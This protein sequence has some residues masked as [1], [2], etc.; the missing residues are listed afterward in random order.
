MWIVGEEVR[1]NQSGMAWGVLFGVVFVKVFY[2]IGPMNIELALSG[3]ISDPVKAHV[4]YFQLFLLDGVV[5]KTLSCGVI[6]TD[7]GD[8][9]RIDKLCESGADGYRFLPVD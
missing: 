1:V 2:S 6:R 7:G 8:R 4:N 9:L 3:A 5:G